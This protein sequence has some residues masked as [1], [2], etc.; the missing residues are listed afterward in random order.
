METTYD[1]GVTP[2]KG[3]NRE[4]IRKGRRSPGKVA[5]DRVGPIVDTDEAVTPKRKKPRP[6]K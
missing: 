2:G 1:M 4:D 3:A 5:K 6:K